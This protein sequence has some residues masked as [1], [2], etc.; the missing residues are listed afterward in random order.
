MTDLDRFETNPLSNVIGSLVFAGVSIWFLTRIDRE[1]CRI[2]EARRHI[3]EG[4][5]TYEKE[6]KK[7]RRGVCLFYVVCTILSLCVSVFSAIPLLR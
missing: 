4:T 3:W 1:A 5:S 7:Y 6:F 2:V